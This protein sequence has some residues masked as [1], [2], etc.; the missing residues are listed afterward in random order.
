M[1]SSK[2]EV[3]SSRFKS[4]VKNLFRKVKTEIK[5]HKL[6]YFILFLILAFSAFF[7]LFRLHDLLGFWFDQGRDAL[8]IWD[9]LRYGKFFLIGPVTG[10]E[11]IF[12]GPFYYYLIAPFYWL[13]GGSPVFVAAALAWLTV[14][15]IFLIYTLAAKIYGRGVGLL[16]AFI[17]GFSYGLVTFSR[18][19][20]NPNPLPFFT[21][22]ALIL[23]YKFIVSHNSLFIILYSFVIGLCLQLEAASAVWFLPSTLVVLVWQRK[24][25]RK[26]LMLLFAF[27]AFFV[28]L[29]PQIVF[30]LR[31]DGIL[32][33]AFKRFLISEKSFGLSLAQTVRLRLVTYY[34]V[35]FGKLFP[36]ISWLRLVT[37]ALFSAGLV[38]FRKKI[39][40]LGG[41]LLFIWFLVPLIGFFFYRGNHGYVWDYYF[42]GFIPAFA[43]LLAAVFYHIIKKHLVGKVLV[44]GLLIVF[45]ATNLKMIKNYHQTGIGITLKAQLW[46]IDW[47]YKDAGEED[48][49]VDVYV[50]PQIYFSYSYLLRWYGKGKYGKEP[51]TNQV[52]NLYTLAEPDGE[53]P[54]FLQNWLERQDKIGRIVK[55]DSWGDITVHKRE[56][57]IYEE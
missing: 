40:T 13:G 28:T 1:I 22:I 48:F 3:Q 34:D 5:T 31:H 9:L 50:P 43:I 7:R 55:T 37:L 17:Y 57:Q 36:A 14:A 52:K 8:I 18:W 49:N 38:L 23:L 6:V 45:A 21:L 25:F 27:L 2:R 42:T 35:F 15:A 24:I 29:L 54:Q 51:N 30:N 39:F 56:R 44:G 10:I 32:V 11:G 4:K 16:A 19:L 33:D 12:L 46:A 41:K 20:A 47:I 26:P 53:H